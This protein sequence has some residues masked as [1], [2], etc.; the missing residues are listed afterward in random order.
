M[1]MSLMFPPS[2]ENLA[3]SP[4]W[5]INVIYGTVIDSYTLSTTDELTASNSYLLYHLEFSIVFPLY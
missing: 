1:F 2:A 3:G 4:V 5:Q